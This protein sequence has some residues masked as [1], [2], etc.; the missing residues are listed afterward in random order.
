VPSPPSPQTPPS[1]EQIQAAQVALAQLA[2]QSVDQ[3]WPDDPLADLAALAVETRDH[4]QAAGA[5]AVR[6]YRLQRLA[7]GERSAF[8]AVTA[9]VPTVAEL[10]AMLR[11]AGTREAAAKAAGEATFDQG[12]RTV[13]ANVDRDRKARGY[14]RIPEPN[15]CAFCLM[16]ATRGAV[17]KA[18]RKGRVANGRGKDL[19]LQGIKKGQRHGAGDS[20]AASNAKFTDGK[21][22]SS[23]KVHDNCACLPE[24]VFGVYEAPARVRAADALWIKAIAPTKKAPRGYG[25][26]R[27]RLRFRQLVEGRLPPDDE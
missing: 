21:K 13:L 20:F 6:Q 25:G 24:P 4:A 5:L 18:D 23:I 9:A 15:A 7:A 11:S 3:L 10:E 1:P 22:A 8:R 16:L 17:Y 19:T 14:A 2:R 12:V 26:D 27:A